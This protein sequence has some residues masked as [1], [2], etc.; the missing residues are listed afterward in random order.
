ME[1]NCGKVT[2]LSRTLTIL[3]TKI[4]PPIPRMEK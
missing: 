3:A 2:P 1:Y 4:P